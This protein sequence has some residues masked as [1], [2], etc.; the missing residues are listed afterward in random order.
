MLPPLVNVPWLALLTIAVIFPVHGQSYKYFR[1]GNLAD[2]HTTPVAGYALMG[3]GKDLDDAF[4]WLCERA[5]GGDFWFYMRTATMSTTRTSMVFAKQT[6]W[7]RKSGIREYEKASFSQEWLVG[8]LSS[9]ECLYD[10][11]SG[12]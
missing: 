7:I 4:K 1:V 3:G 11:R 5:S 8:C 12:S 9:E 10:I 2:V 6:R